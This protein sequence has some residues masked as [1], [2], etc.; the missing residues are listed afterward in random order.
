MSS[1]TDQAQTSLPPE[2]RALPPA[3]QAELARRVLA[4]RNLLQFVLRFFPAYE[5]GWVHE[6]IT[7]RLEAFSRAVVERRSP[8]LMLLMPPRT[9]KSTLASIY[10]PAWHL[11]HHP[12]HDVILSSYNLDLPMKFSRK[13]R[14]LVKEP[15]YAALFE[16]TRLHPE[17]QSAEQ[18]ETTQ[19]GV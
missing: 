15:R 12:T 13:V 8:R 11:G 10:F 19:G 17:S 18:W 2:L 4:R 7:R 5:A 14:D 6:D 1:S 3:A 9:G 16:A